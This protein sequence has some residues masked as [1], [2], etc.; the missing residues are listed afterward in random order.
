[1]SQ[2]LAELTQ[3]TNIVPDASYI[4]RNMGSQL[5]VGHPSDSSCRQR[6]NYTSRVALCGRFD[7]LNDL[8]MSVPWRLLREW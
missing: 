6:D 5:E 8:L 2:E 7:T 1:M 4:S 3:D